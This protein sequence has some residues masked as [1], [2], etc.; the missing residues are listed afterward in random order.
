MK[1]KCHIIYVQ[2]VDQKNV[3]QI[4]DGLTEAVLKI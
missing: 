2:T 3:K 4:G 1:L